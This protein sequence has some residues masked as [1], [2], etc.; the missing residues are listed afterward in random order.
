MMSEEFP[1]S[2]RLFEFSGRIQ[3]TRVLFTTTSL[4]QKKYFYLSIGEKRV[5]GK[6]FSENGRDEL[7]T[8]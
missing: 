7:F 4:L 3:N 6:V 2:C 8:A 5:A 1:D